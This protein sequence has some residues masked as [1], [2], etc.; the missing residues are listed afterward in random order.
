MEG[1]GTLEITGLTSPAAGEQAIAECGSLVGTQ[2][3][4][5]RG[6]TP[7]CVVYCGATSIGLR[8]IAGVLLQ[9]E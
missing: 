9:F 7:D 1:A 5:V 4:N 3:A 6:L 8:E 2:F